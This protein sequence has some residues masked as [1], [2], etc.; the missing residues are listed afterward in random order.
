[1]AGVAGDGKSRLR[2]IRI[3]GPVVF[4][5]VTGAASPA[6]Q[7]VVPVYVALQAGQIGVLS[8]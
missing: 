2:M 1:M 5:H 4:L 8:G 7:V 3:G 6:G